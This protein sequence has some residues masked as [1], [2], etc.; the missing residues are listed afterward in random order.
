MSR[1]GVRSTNREAIV[2]WL[3]AEDAVQWIENTYQQVWHAGGRLYKKNSFAHHADVYKLFVEHKPEIFL[4]KQRVIA[5]LKAQGVTLPDDPDVTATSHDIYIGLSIDWSDVRGILLWTPQLRISNY[6]PESR[7]LAPPPHAYTSPPPTI[8]A[9]TAADILWYHFR[10]LTSSFQSLCD[11]FGLRPI[12]TAT[13]N[14]QQF[15]PPYFS[16]AKPTSMPDDPEEFLSPSSLSALEPFARACLRTYDLLSTDV[17]ASLL[18]RKLLTFRRE[19]SIETV[20]SSVYLVIPWLPEGAGQWAK[21]EE[22]VCFI[23]DQLSCMDFAAQQRLWLSSWPVGGTLRIHR[24]VEEYL[25][26]CS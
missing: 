16:Y 13:M 5:C 6:W 11:A 9:E 14:S 24:P 8:D 10:E 17:T 25:R 26:H 22:D 1:F 18:R 2:N 15:F 20:L 21:M 23:A 12:W 4:D 7:Q 3:P 19:I